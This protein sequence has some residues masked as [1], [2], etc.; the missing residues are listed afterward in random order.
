[1]KSHQQTRQAYSSMYTI[2]TLAELDEKRKTYP[3][4]KVNE[5]IDIFAVEKIFNP[6]P[7]HNNCISL[8]LFCQNVDNKTPALITTSKPLDNSPDSRWNTKYFSS[9]KTFI[10]DVLKSPFSKT[11]K[12]RIYLE[13][14]LHEHYPKVFIDLAPANVEVYLM[15][16]NSIGAQPG[17]LW[18]YL[19]FDD[20]NLDL[21]FVS[22]VDVTFNGW[23]VNKL[24]L[25]QKSNKTFGRFLGWHKNN[26]TIG[27]D[28]NNPL[29]YPVCLGS[30]IAMRPK[31]FNHP[32]ITVK[33]TFINYILYRIHRIETSNKPWEEKDSCDTSKYNRPV[34]GH[35][36]GWGGYWTMYGFDEKVFKHTL[37]PHFIERQE[38][39]T[40]TSKG[41]FEKFETMDDNHPFK[42]DVN[43]TKTFGNHI[44]FLP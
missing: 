27:N 30:A 8:T 41:N 28:L 24:K 33:R 15:K 7:H 4:N 19:A 10:R 42:I 22:D 35:S 25:F 11:F 17:M 9:L 38:V 16:H 6:L 43:Y 34:E 18:R 12:I 36:F 32:T 21:V 31:Q 29:N 2:L 20:K 44:V 23:V 26:L 1:M 37:F 13:K 5:I 39:Q 14:Q 3:T 40:W